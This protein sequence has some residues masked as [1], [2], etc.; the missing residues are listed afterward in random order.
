MAATALWSLSNLN[1]VEMV[2]SAREGK[3]EWPRAILAVSKQEEVDYTIAMLACLKVGLEVV[4]VDKSKLGD[5]S[6]LGE[7]Q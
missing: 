4:L 2:S 6:Y 7:Y 5:P 1:V 3:S